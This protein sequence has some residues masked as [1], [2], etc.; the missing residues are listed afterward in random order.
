MKH[1]LTLFIIILLSS[2]LWAQ[3]DTVL[4]GKKAVISWVEDGNEHY[5]M[6][7]YDLAIDFYGLAL[8]SGY[9]SADLYYNLGNAYYRTDQ[10]WL[11][12]LNYKRALRL[13]PSMSD[14]KENLALAE[15]HTIDRIAVLP[16]FFLVRWIDALC[17]HISPA[18]WRII[19]L[20]L[21]AL[22]GAALFCFLRGGSRNVR[23]TGF[24]AGVILIVLLALSTWLLLRTTHRYNAHN[25]AVV[26]FPAITVKSSPE[27][28]SVDKLILHEGTTVTVCDSLAGWYKIT[29][30]DGTTGWCSTDEVE[31]I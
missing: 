18:L 1:I 14:A 29:L 20:V 8:S 7:N 30:A 2:G 22:L 16:Q 27:Q 15:S 10:T 12:I 28:Q 24:V 21:L 19:W 5:R 3:D 13:D 23:K 6:G 9:A 17:T 11:A 26:A 4:T 31:R 25:D